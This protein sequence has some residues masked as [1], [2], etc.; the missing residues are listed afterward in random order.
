LAEKLVPRDGQGRRKLIAQSVQGGS[1]L[2][3]VRKS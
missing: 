3:M 1:R 2:A